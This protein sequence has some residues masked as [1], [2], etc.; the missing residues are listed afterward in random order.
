MKQL[1]K[2]IKILIYVLKSIYEVLYIYPKFRYKTLYEIEE[3]L[4]L[5]KVS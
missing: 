5:N 2:I 3:S 1:K 4:K